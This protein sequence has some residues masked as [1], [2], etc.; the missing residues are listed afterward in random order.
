MK[1]SSKQTLIL[2]SGLVV[3]LFVFF[4]SP[5]LAADF[6]FDGAALC[7]DTGVDAGAG[8]LSCRLFNGDE[9]NEDLDVFLNDQISLIAIN[10]PGS[11]TLR[12]DTRQTS[13]F[14][15][16]LTYTDS[17]CACRYNFV[18]NGKQTDEDGAT[19]SSLVS[20]TEG[21][22]ESVFSDER[23][24]GLV[25]IPESDEKPRECRVILQNLCLVTD[26]GSAFVGSD[27]TVCDNNRTWN[28]AASAYVI[29]GLSTV[30]DN[31]PIS[32]EAEDEGAGND[33]PVEIPIGL[34]QKVQ[35]LYTWAVGLAGIVALGIIIFG[36]VLYASSAG[37]PS[38]MTEAKSWITHALLGLSLLFAAHLILGFI[39][40]NLTK[41]DEIFLAQNVNPQSGGL[42]LEAGAGEDAMCISRALANTV[43]YGNCDGI[44]TTQNARAGNF[45]DQRCNF[46]NG[47]TVFEQGLRDELRAR[48]IADYP[49]LCEWRRNRIIGIIVD[50]LIPCE[51]GNT[52]SPNSVRL[53]GDVGLDTPECTGAWGLFQMGKHPDRGGDGNPAT[54]NVGDVDW[55]EQVHNAAHHLMEYGEGY[56]V[57]DDP[58]T[59][60]CWPRSET[61][62]AILN[63]SCTG[64]S[65]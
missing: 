6:S 21:K 47:L 52:F 65:T 28:D 60:S 11:I 57:P 16:T 46:K 42:E 15:L 3:C 26:E 54:Y 10:K 24:S 61:M 30:D 48:L 17:S 37:N 33:E 38:R 13:P 55:K 27:G 20:C 64:N 8:A 1:K 29:Q 5:A 62:D 58:N 34:S 9:T 25:I 56:W 2:L 18:T 23:L 50:E 19:A 4:I 49:D 36:G 51:T 41:L 44:Y 14:A 22:K 43:D 12:A 35:N 40:P 59:L 63:E 7:V 53:R 32:G 39:N 45:G 31:V